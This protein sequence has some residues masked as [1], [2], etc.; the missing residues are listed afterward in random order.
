MCRR[1]ARPCRGAAMARSLRP[2]T[3][4]TSCR[5]FSKAGRPR[6]AHSS[7]QSA[8]TG[9]DSGEQPLAYQR[10]LFPLACQPLQRTL[11][12]RK[13]TPK[14]AMLRTRN[15]ERQLTQPHCATSPS[16]GGYAPHSPSENSFA[17]LQTVANA[18]VLDLAWVL[19][20]D[21]PPSAERRGEAKAVEKLARISH[22]LPTAAPPSSALAALR[23][24][25]LLC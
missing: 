1:S 14:Q 5:C 24:L 12:N 16:G 4:S 7:G 11:R 13:I 15:H 9:W 17:E 6:Q 19:L 3:T 8:R 23:S 21:E 25:G 22:G 18:E 10:N 2:G 20:E